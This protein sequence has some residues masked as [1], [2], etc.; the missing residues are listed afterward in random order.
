[1]LTL[2]SIENFAIIESL[3]I[4]FSKGMT[5]LMGETGAGKSIIIDALS[6]L[7]G[8][9]S[10]SSD[11]R[12]QCDR[13][14][15]QAQYYFD[16]HESLAK[17]LNDHG[18]LFQNE[19]VLYREIHR[20]G[21]NVIRINGVLSTVALLKEIGRFVIDIHGQHEHQLLL[22]AE[23]HL[24]YLDQFGNKTLQPLILDYQEKYSIYVL[25]KKKLKSLMLSEQ[26]DAQRISLIEQQKKEI[27]SVQPLPNEDNL[28][29]EELQILTKN[30]EK[31][32]WLTQLHQ[33]VFNEE[34]V[35]ISTFN[36]VSSKMSHSDINDNAY[37]NFNQ[38]L[39][40]VSDLLKEIEKGSLN[41]LEQLQFNP[42]R[43]DAL[44]L[45]LQQLDDLKI[46][47]GESIDDV[48]SYFNQI[49]QELDVLVNKEKYIQ[50]GQN[51]FLTA[52]EQ[53]LIAGQLLSKTR[54]ELAKQ[55]ENVIHEQLKD[56]Y[57][58]KVTF[59]VHFDDSQSSKIKKTGLDNV[60]FY[61]STNVG[62]PFKSLEKVASG[63]EMS[64]IMLALKTIF[65]SNRRIGTIVFDE[66]DT[67]VS[68]RVAEAIGQK[69]A[70]IGRNTQVLAITHL[71]QVAAVADYQI[72]VIK[73]VVGE[74]TRTVIKDLT[75][76]ERVIEIAK[77]ITGDEIAESALIHAKSLREMSEQFKRKL[78]D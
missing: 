32:E 13:A 54:K 15:V 66:I 28:L 48:I 71:P 77:M 17:I 44:F 60:S 16:S 14:I 41:L 18:I 56:L 5:V 59:N 57:M 19:L 51:E 40:L 49:S 74:R 23:N 61:I 75:E 53:L 30:K 26:Q 38:Q 70:I 37:E 21:R 45:R 20:N 24:N 3:A 55:L 8:G 50:I 22:N 11:I 46:K 64:R 78:S 63:G 72:N 33:N 36:A 69:M 62:E 73:E 58:E 67:G 31:F 39:I 52:R 7:A 25:A 34:S 2:L 68:G 10:S 76:E 35:L 4:D 42:E 1:M 29:K 27:E 43:F 12:Y 47:Y 9:R 6:Y 65:F